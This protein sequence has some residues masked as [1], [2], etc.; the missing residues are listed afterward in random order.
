[1]GM[2]VSPSLVFSLLLASLYGAVFHFVWGKRWR[3][4]ALYWM[5]AVIG[6]AIGQALFNFLGFSIYLIG[7]VRVVEST[8]VSWVCLFVARWLNI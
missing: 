4:L 5:V 3:D 2:A 1:M 7:E 8:I 6:F